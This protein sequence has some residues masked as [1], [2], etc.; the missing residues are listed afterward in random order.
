MVN[1]Y[2][3]IDEDLNIYV[4][5]KYLV[6]TSPKVAVQVFFQV[7]TAKLSHLN[8]MLALIWHFLLC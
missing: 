3:V 6:G 4:P 2:I 8:S 7:V 5:D 1:L